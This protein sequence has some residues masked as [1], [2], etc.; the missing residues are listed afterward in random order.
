[1]P[2]KSWPPRTDTSFKGIANHRRMLTY[3]ERKA[4]QELQEVDA[5]VKDAKDPQALKAAESARKR[6]RGNLTKQLGIGLS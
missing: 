2:A 5:V 4:R 1:M 6:C 3:I